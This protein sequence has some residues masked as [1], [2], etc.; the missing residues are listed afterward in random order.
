MSPITICALSY[1]EK[2]S[3]EHKEGAH[4][5]EL[6]AGQ[7]SP[8]AWSRAELVW[9]LDCEGSDYPASYDDADVPKIHSPDNGKV[10]LVFVSLS[11]VKIEYPLLSNRS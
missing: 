3:T 10:I 1:L 11:I 9:L 8:D 4:L 6:G 5:I 2:Y 7:S